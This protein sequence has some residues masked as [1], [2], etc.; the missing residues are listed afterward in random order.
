MGARADEAGR[1]RGDGPQHPERRDRAQTAKACVQE[2]APLLEGN[3]PDA[4][5]SVLRRAREAEP[6]QERADQP[7]GQPGPAARERVQLELV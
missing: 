4:V 7:D 5:E 3:V 2:V 1:D 6:R